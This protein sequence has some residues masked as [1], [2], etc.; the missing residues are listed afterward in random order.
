MKITTI[1]KIWL[2]FLTVSL[3]TLISCSDDSFKFK[4]TC[5]GGAE[6]GSGD[7]S[8]SYSFDNKQKGEF[9]GT[10]L[11]DSA[12]IYEHVQ[13]ISND[14]D[15]LSISASRDSY[16]S[17][18]VIKVYMNGELVKDD[19]LSSA[20]EDSGYNTLTLEYEYGEN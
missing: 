17:T 7:F 12:K 6:S 18:L 15:N 3:L 14:F 9:S 4:V 19:T 5:Y 1:K 11:E 13:K 8:G 16:D 2:L 20:T 10:K